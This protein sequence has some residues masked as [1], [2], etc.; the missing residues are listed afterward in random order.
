MRQRRVKRTT[1][2][3]SPCGCDQALR[4][5]PGV[6]GGIR[7][8]GCPYEID[9]GAWRERGLLKMYSGVWGGAPEKFGE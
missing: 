9:E 2:E 3:Q 5:W 7:R 4:V 6:D 8:G 1:A